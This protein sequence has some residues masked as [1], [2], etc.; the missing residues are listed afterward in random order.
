MPSEEG[1]WYERAATKFSLNL[2]GTI[3][4]LIGVRG[5]RSCSLRFVTQDN[6]LI[7]VVG[8]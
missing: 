1:A 6:V 2:R 4:A 5:G 7:T 3:T 8:G